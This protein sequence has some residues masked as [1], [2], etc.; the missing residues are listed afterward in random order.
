MNPRAAR[1]PGMRKTRRA[2]NGALFMD[3]KLARFTGIIVAALTLVASAALADSA[4]NRNGQSTV[5]DLGR[6]FQRDR[7][8]Y[9]R[10]AQ[11]SPIQAWLDQE[12]AEV[13]WDERSFEEIIDWLR[14][15]PGEINIDL[16]W[17]VLEGAGVDREAPVTLRFKKIRLAILLDKILKQAG[18]DIHLGYRGIGN[19]LEISTA[20]D[21]D[22]RFVIRTY[23]VTDVVRVIVNFDQS[24]S[25]QLSQL[26]QAQYGGGGGGGNASNLFSDDDDDEEDTELSERMQALIDNIVQVVEPSSW[27][28]NGGLGTIVFV[29]D[30]LV[31]NNSIKVHETLGGPVRLTARDRY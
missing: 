24:P 1:E 31:V 25:I 7:Q 4:T 29:N 13:D 23:P 6:R 2:K 16:N 20:E 30:V 22:S 14:E 15:L 11:L 8:R 5:G 27:Q 12:I 19:V 17:L 3:T 18:G 9:V 10:H 26:Q 28:Q 21:F